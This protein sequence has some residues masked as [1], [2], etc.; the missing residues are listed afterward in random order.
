[1]KCICD[2]HEEDNLDSFDANV[3]TTGVAGLYSIYESIL[4]YTQTNEFYGA[5][6]HNDGN[7]YY[8]TSDKRFKI[9]K[10]K[11]IDNWL[12]KFDDKATILLNDKRD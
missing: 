8:F 4:M 3:I 1:M 11:N 12:K 5:F 6:L 2:I 9:E 10:P 7:I